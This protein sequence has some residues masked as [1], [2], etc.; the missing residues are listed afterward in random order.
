V[1]WSYPLS[2]CVL[3]CPR[4]VSANHYTSR[5]LPL[6]TH[7]ETALRSFHRF[8][9]FYLF[10]RLN[11]SLTSSFLRYLLSREAIC[12][13][14]KLIPL[15]TIVAK[16]LQYY[17]FQS[18]KLPLRDASARWINLLN[19]KLIRRYQYFNLSMTWSKQFIKTLL[20]DIAQLSLRRYNLFDWQRA[21]F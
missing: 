9:Y 20:N 14:H 13:H 2:H 7:L 17:K 3:E 21:P 1:I 19:Y 11:H 10:H 6:Q 4:R 5:A 15:Q 16:P 12:N 8:T 18:C